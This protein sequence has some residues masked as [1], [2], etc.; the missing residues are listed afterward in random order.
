MNKK[1]YRD[2]YHRVFG[3][4]CSGLAEYFDVDVVVVRLL[5][6]FT[7]FAGGVGFIPYLILWIVL[8]KRGYMYNRFNNPTVDYTVPPQQPGAPYN[9]PQPNTFS[10]PYG[11]FS[12]GFEPMPQRK[13][14]AG[15]IIGMVLIALGG[16]ILIDEY[17]LI[18]DFDFERI[19][20]VILVIVGGALIATG[21][22]KEPWEKA[23]WK[24][25]NIKEATPPPATDATSG[26]DNTTTVEP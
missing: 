3:G 21:Q 9:A 5:F 4:V 18:P 6:V 2:E 1:L 25:E 8:P 17:N 19:W 13:S 24:N 16:I 26:S 22:R 23:D 11:N 7:F 14:N 15:V 20:P 12:Q 10:G